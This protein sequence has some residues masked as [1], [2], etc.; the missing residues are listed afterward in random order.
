M[1]TQGIT[2]RLANRFCLL[3]VSQLQ[4]QVSRSGTLDAWALAL[5]V[6]AVVLGLAGVQ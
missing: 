5:L 6:L 1:P 3:A 4:T 2:P